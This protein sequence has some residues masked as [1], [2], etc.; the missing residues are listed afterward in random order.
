VLNKNIRDLRQQSME[1]SRMAFKAKTILIADDDEG[2]RLLT[3]AALAGAG[4][5]VVVAH[6]GAQAVQEF[7]VCHPDLV[8][9]DVMMPNMTGIEACAAI[10]AR[11]DGQHLPVLMLTGRNDLAAI[12]DAYAAG[13]SDFAQ[14]G[15]NPRLLVERV[16]FLLRDQELQND[17]WSSRSKLLLAQRIA[18][19]GHWE[20]DLEGRTVSLSPM[21]G[22]LLGVDAASLQD[23]EHFVTR[24]NPVERDAVREAFRACAAGAGGFSFDH[25]VQVTRGVELCLHQEGELIQPSGPGDPNVVIVTLQDLTRLRDAEENVHRLSYFDTA[26]GLHNRRHLVERITDALADT[27]GMT[28]TVGVVAI[29]LHNLDRLLQVHGAPFVSALVTEVGKG[30]QDELVRVG[31]GGSVVWR[32][33]I[34]AVCRIADGELAMLLRSRGSPEQLADVAHNLLAAV[35]HPMVCLGAEYL[36]AVSAGIA[37]APRDGDEAERLLTNAHCAAQQAT[38]VRSCAFFSQAQGARSR[39]RILMES[40]LRGAI[41]RRELRLAYQPRVTIDTLDL[42]GVECLL[43]W[44]HPQFGSVAP[45]EF[46]SIA[47]ETGFIDEIG[48]WVVREA[49]RQLADWRETFQ[50]MFFVSVKVSGRQ[51][52]DPQLVTTVKDILSATQLP[53]NA[54]ELQLKEAGLIDAGKDARDRLAA[55][56]SAGVRI[57]IDDFGTGYSSLG[58][59]RRLPFDCMKLDRSLIADLYSDLGATGVTSAVVAMARAL[60]I[61]SVAEGIEDA[62]TLDMIRSI[63]CDEIQGFYVMRPLTA[64]DFEQWLTAGGA[65]ALRLRQA[66]VLD[67]ELEAEDPTEPR[68]AGRATG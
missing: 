17:V 27:D 2:H 54:L 7:G 48:R 57:A 45:D 14:K 33:D 66:L 13:A 61:C 39:V 19:V 1:D 3:E 4:Y 65:A 12:S 20:L 10:R 16:R 43:R 29:R 11:P 6:D 49:C 52:R 63:G 58:L 9:L 32:H 62:A 40:A 8:I 36:P 37:L 42:T 67:G 25:R 38:D 68:D 64:A 22:V 15:L 47:E 21:A 35:S 46:I 56:R 50:N 60:Q 59:L 41:E 55:L 51:L 53:G 23:Y 5:V 26:T 18:R 24:L 44:E 30:M 34:D 31:A 28:A